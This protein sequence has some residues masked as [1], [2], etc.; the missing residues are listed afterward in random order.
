[1][2]G[3]YKTELIYGPARSGPWK[4]VEDVELATL[5]WCTGTT[6]AACTA[7][8]ATYHRRSSKPRSTMP[9]GATN[10]GRNPIA[11]ASGKPRAIHI[12]SDTES[13]KLLP[14]TDPP[15]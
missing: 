4:T 5:G 13:G 12:V 8:S 10:P 7:T 3:Y 11:R 9:N 1:M 2:N 15:V 14:L 6:P